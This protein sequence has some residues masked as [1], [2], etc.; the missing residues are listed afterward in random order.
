MAKGRAAAAGAK[1][2]VGLIGKAVP[3]GSIR[4][5]KS[6]GSARSTIRPAPCGPPRPADLGESHLTVPAAEL[7]AIGRRYSG[8]G[9]QT[10]RKNV[11]PETGGPNEVL[12][13][14]D[15]SGKVTYY[16]V[17]DKDGLPVK[18]VD[19]DPNSKPHNDIGPPHT[20]E[21]VLD[22]DPKT[23]RTWPKP[24]TVRKS[25]PIELEGLDEVRRPL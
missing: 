17:Y 5:A 14:T 13:R 23:G 3:F 8:T 4:R 16:K 10:R 6:L 7:I 22:R 24:G 12:Y 15:Q 20:E 2:L 18:R 19:V 21:Y 25:Y 1:K 11:F 9:R